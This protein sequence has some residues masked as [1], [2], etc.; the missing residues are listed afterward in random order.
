MFLWVF[1]CVLFILSTKSWPASRHDE[2]VYHTYNTVHF[3]TSARNPLGG[4][5][6]STL[7]QTDTFG[8]GTLGHLCVHLG[9]MSV[10]QRVK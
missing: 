1:V 9:E 6:Q 7:S 10:L 4:T 5:V 3:W 8:N 2:H